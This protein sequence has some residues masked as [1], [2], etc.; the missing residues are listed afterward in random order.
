MFEGPLALWDYFFTLK[1]TN[2]LATLL[3]I[4]VPVVA[5]WRFVTRQ[6]RLKTEELC[7]LQDLCNIRYQLNEDQK[8]ELERRDKTIGV[9]ESQLPAHWLRQAAKE[10]EESNEESAIRCLRNGF[11]SIRE[12]L[13]ACCFD[14]AS[15]H[16]SL[17]TDYGKHHFGEAKR[18]A[19]IAMLLFPSDRDK[20]LFL[21]E[22]LAAEAEGKYASGDYKTYDSL[23]EEAEDFLKIGNDPEIIATLGN[24]ALQ[25]YKQGR[26]RL[27]VLLLSRALRMCQRHLGKDSPTT[28]NIRSWHARSLGAA[29][30][31]RESLALFQALLPDEERV[32]GKDHPD[33]LTTRY[34]IARWTG[35]AGDA[36]EALREFKALLPDMERVNGKD[37][38]DTLATRYDIARWTG[39]AGD[40][41][42]ALQEFK[43]LLPDEERVK[44]KDHPDTLMTRHGIADWT[45]VAGDAVGALREFKTLLPDE[46]R[47]KG[48]GHPD[49]LTTRSGI[50]HWTGRAGDAAGALALFQALL[51]DQERV[52]GKDHPDTRSTREK[53]ESLK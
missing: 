41:A 17:I 20:Q 30:R 10:R 9:L 5:Y 42:E 24:Q 8:Q 2:Q 45:G 49:I 37:R 14:L 43:A 47:V 6:L 46:E 50:A 18:L 39:K 31:Y 1:L 15:H 53:I 32:I 35:Q 11:E 44:G 52:K 48:K 19:Q 51:P 13:S 38:P 4:S 22:I 40:A 29:G 23:W 33:T 21:A 36:A 25:H 12:A 16:F 26:Y 27:A 34:D 7:K 3:T 28:L